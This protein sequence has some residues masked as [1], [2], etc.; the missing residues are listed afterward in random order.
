MK[1]ITCDSDLA[2]NFFKAWKCSLTYFG[3]M[4]TEFLPMEGAGREK[5]NACCFKFYF[6]TCSN[7][8]TNYYKFQPLLITIQNFKNSH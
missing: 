3:S 2:R 7:I 1:I 4:K 6:L 8:T 5:K